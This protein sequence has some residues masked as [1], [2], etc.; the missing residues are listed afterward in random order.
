MLMVEKSWEPHPPGTLMT[1]P[2][3]YR[4]CLTNLQE[5]TVVLKFGD[6]RTVGSGVLETEEEWCAVGPA[7]VK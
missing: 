3:L 1:Y 4:D 7:L 6:P 2:C 5:T